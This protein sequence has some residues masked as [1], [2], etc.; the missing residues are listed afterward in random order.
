MAKNKA[1]GDVGQVDGAQDDF[2]GGEEVV[3]SD[4]PRYAIGDP[5]VDNDDGKILGMVE[6]TYEDSIEETI[7][8]KVRLA[9]RLL[10]RVPVDGNKRILLWGNYQLDA[11]LPTLTRGTKVRITYKG[12]QP[13]RGGKTLKIID[14]QF[15]AKAE[16]RQNPFR[17]TLAAQVSN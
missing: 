8:G 1:N 10:P 13:M 5:S 16:R 7:E 11:A 15:S 3:S 17:E 4:L 9:H 2:F 14:V 6:G 12:T